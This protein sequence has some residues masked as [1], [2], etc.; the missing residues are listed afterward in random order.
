MLARSPKPSKIILLSA[1][2]YHA[3]FLVSILA[4]FRLTTE[5]SLAVVPHKQP[6]RVAFTGLISPKSLKSPSWLNYFERKH[7]AEKRQVSLGTFIKIPPRTSS[8]ILLDRFVRDANKTDPGGDFFQLWRAGLNLRHGLSLFE[9]YGAGDDPVKVERLNKITPFHPPNR[10]LPAMIYAVGYPLSFLTP[11]HAYLGWLVVHELAL[12]FCIFISRRLSTQDVSRT[13]VTAMWLS[14]LPYYLEMYM[15]QTSFIIM[16]GVMAMVY[17]LERQKPLLAGLWWSLTL[18][19]KPLTLLLVPA[20]AVAKRWKMILAG[21]GILIGSSAPYFLSRPLDFSLFMDWAF[22]QEIVS[23]VG[24]FCAQNLFYHLHYSAL[25]TKALS[26]SLLALGVML[27][28]WRRRF[29]FSTHVCLW[30][31]TYFVTYAHVWEH[32]YVMFLPVLILLF[33]KGQRALAVGCYLALAIPSPF[34]I[35]EGTGSW[36]GEMLYLATKVIPVL[37]IYA[38]IVSVYVKGGGAPPKLNV[39]NP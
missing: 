19:T 6:D 36:F 28:I 24:A 16:T 23:N 17:Y 12:G 27:T 10:Y 39:P 7:A 30:L 32:H 14:F 15:G 8:N 20:L 11:V 22:G 31:T 4:H 18:L 2:L 1:M 21:C 33:L 13:I 26:Y 34:F 29:A 5:P 37:V 3:L 25:A 38:V 35:Y 9:N